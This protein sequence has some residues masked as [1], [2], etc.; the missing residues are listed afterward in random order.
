MA[1]LIPQSGRWVIQFTLR[2]ERKRRTISLGRMSERKAREF[3]GNVEELIANRNGG[4]PISR[5]TAIWAECLQ[6]WL[7]NKLVKVGLDPRTPQVAPPSTW[8]RERKQRIALFTYFIQRQ[9]GGPI[10]IG[11][12]DNIAKRLIGLQCGSPVALVCLGF[13]AGDREKE[14]H[15]QFQSLRLS[16]EWFQ[17]ERELLD[18]ITANTE[19][20]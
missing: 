8:K 4:Y 6:G 1:S 3:F 12:T 15:G 10:K 14:L 16:G 20:M 5:D 18:F 11:I 9:D 2:D 19:K 17:P 7:L 13:I